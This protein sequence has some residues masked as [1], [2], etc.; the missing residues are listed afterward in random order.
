[1]E[2]KIILLSFAQTFAY[3]LPANFKFYFEQRTIVCSKKFLPPLRFNPNSLTHEKNYP[4]KPASF[5][6]CGD[7]IAPFFFSGDSRR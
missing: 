7:L 4:K 3:A 5:A 2:I 1:L 6:F